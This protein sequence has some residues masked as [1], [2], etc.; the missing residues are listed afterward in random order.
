MSTLRAYNALQLSGCNLNT[1]RWPHQNPFPHL[2][3]F[4]GDRTGTDRQA[5]F[6]T[7]GHFLLQAKPKYRPVLNIGANTCIGYTNTG[8][9]LKYRF[10]QHAVMGSQHSNSRLAFFHIY[11]PPFTHLGVFPPVN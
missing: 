6:A 7:F 3:P 5:S 11:Q 9:H 4:G 10:L 2:L 8:L 1:A